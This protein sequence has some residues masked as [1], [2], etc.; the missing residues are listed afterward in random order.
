[1]KRGRILRIRSRLINGS[2]ETCIYRRSCRGWKCIIR[3]VMKPTD[4]WGFTFTQH[5]IKP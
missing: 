4:I 1:M 2:Y 5:I 3:Y